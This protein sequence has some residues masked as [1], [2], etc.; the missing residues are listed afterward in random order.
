MKPGDVIDNK[1]RIETQLGEGGM[2]R[3]MAATHVELG[4]NVAIKILKQDALAHPE[5]PKRFMR[6]AR[7]AGRLRNEHVVRVVDVGRLASGEPYMVMEML[8]GYDLATRL[9]KGALVTPK[10]R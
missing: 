2:G 5:V 9:Q 3:V 4:S 1:Y 7:A 10:H 6:E 8:H